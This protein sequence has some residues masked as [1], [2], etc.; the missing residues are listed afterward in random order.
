VK[1]HREAKTVKSFKESF[2]DKQRVFDSLFT[3]IDPSYKAKTAVLPLFISPAVQEKI[4]YRALKKKYFRTHLWERSMD[5]KVMNV[6]IGYFF[7]WFFS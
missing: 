1:T 7:K 2:I 6:R 5:G 3:A 4:N